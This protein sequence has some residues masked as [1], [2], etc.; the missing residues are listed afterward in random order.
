[1]L[2]LRDVL[3][4]RTAYIIR[5]MNRSPLKRRS[6]LRSE[7]NRISAIK[8]RLIWKGHSMLKTQEE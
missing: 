3:K 7:A 4:V 1:M 6:S 8:N 5:A 2:K